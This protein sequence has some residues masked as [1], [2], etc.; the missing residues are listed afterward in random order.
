MS[1]L[2]YT[3]TDSS[4]M[5]SRHL[6]RLV[7]YPSMTLILVGMPIVFLVLFVYVFGGQLGA[8]LGR[9]LGGGHAGRAGYLNTSPRA[10]C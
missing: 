5:L 1:A 9:G 8:H 4:T 2:A 3:L 7:R 6:R 10:S